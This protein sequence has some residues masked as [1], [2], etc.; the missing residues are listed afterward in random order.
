MT[1][2][3]CYAPE[4][5]GLLRIR[6]TRSPDIVL[7]LDMYARTL[8]AL[9]NGISPAGGHS[10]RTF[11][12]PA[13]R[14]PIEAFGD[15]AQLHANGLFDTREEFERHWRTCYPDGERWYRI[16]RLTLSDGY[17]F[18]VNERL[19]IRFRPIE[20]A[21]FPATPPSVLAIGASDG[22]M[23][24][25]T[26]VSAPDPMAGAAPIAPI[27]PDTQRVPATSRIDAGLGL[28]LVHW[29]VH[30][31][32]ACVRLCA[33]NEYNGMLRRRLPF[34]MRTG[35]IPRRDWWEIFPEYREYAL[36]M[37]SSDEISRF[38]RLF[39]GADRCPSAVAD[40][41]RRLPSMT[42]R[43]Y[44][45]ACAAGYQGIGLR[46]P[47]TGGSPFDWYGSYANPQGRA[48]RD[49]DEDSPS[50]FEA[51][52]LEAGERAH[53]WEV[54]SAPGFSWTRLL[55]VHDGSGWSFRI[56]SAAF[57][58]WIEAMPFAL[59]LHD[60]GLPVAVDHAAALV[61]AARGEDVIGIVPHYVP[62]DE[63]GNLFAGESMP[64]MVHLPHERAGS[65]IRRTI[66]DPTPEVHLS[67]QGR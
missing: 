56:A 43:A 54:R 34:D 7:P 27:A 42:A 23:A 36:R 58:S 19:G 53:E 44:V 30:G 24:D 38:E 39:A 65:V 21:A 17:R 31:A 1:T 41:G 46:A 29:L 67:A 16:D 35:R 37:I 11:W 32:E 20:E 28:S 2:A 62:L 22:S 33:R 49:M 66:W 15:F 10:R 18:R 59:A 64:D 55:P 61:Q 3:T 60:A 6:N 14:G 63:G 51:L 12:I 9:T 52:L 57:P 26:P 8:I 5:D 40:G 47:G 45:E 13:E 48:L 50:A 25:V 4:I